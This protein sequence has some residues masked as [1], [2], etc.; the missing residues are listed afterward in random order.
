MSC[1]RLRECGKRV[2]VCEIG[3]EGECVREREREREREE[4]KRSLRRRRGCDNR[5]S[6]YVN[7]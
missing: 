4:G 1:H 7:L 6:K 2:S 3:R 5:T